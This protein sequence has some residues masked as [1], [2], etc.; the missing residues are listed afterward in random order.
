V[1]LDDC[2]QVIRLH[3]LFGGLGLDGCT[4]IIRPHL[5]FGCLGCGLFHVLVFDDLNRR[6]G[7]FDLF[8]FF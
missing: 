8:R 6:L 3:L 7:L 5:L 4:Q 1:D 2:T